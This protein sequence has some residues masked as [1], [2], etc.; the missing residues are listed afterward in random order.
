MAQTVTLKNYNHAKTFVTASGNTTAR[1]ELTF[2]NSSGKEITRYIWKGSP[3]YTQLMENPLATGQQ[4]DVGQ[5]QNGKYWEISTI[6]APG[7]LVPQEYAN[8]TAI[9]V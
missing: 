5:V 9:P 7:S 1:H 6:G 8:T 2:T 4:V 3:L